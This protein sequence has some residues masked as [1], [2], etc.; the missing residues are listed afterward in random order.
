MVKIMMLRLCCEPVRHSRVW[1]RHGET[2]RAASLLAGASALC[3]LG[4][5]YA[6]GG[7]RRFWQM[8]DCAFRLA[9]AAAFLILRVAVVFCLLLA[10]SA[11][12]CLLKYCTARSWASAFCL[13][14]KV[15]KLRRFPVFTFFLREYR[16]YSPDFNLRIMPG[17]M[18]AAERWQ[19]GL[20]TWIR[21]PSAWC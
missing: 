1:S 19:S 8:R 10:I 16:R 20:D 18:P 3:R 4:T 21:P 11:P 12:Q 2:Q 13:D 5:L 6:K 9:A 15:P 14:E 17:V 7:S